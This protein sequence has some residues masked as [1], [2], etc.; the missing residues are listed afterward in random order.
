MTLR[1]RSAQP[2]NGE[3]PKIPARD[4]AFPPELRNRPARRK[5][6]RV[7]AWR[8]KFE[9]KICPAFVPLVGLPRRCVCRSLLGLEVASSVAGTGHHDM[10]PSKR[11]LEL[12]K[13]LAVDQAIEEYP[14]LARW[15]MRY[16]KT[17]KAAGEYVD[18]DEEDEAWDSPVAG[19][20]RLLCDIWPLAEG[21]IFLEWQT[22]GRPSGRGPWW[23]ATF[24]SPPRWNCGTLV[25]RDPWDFAFSWLYSASDNPLVR[26]ELHTLRNVS[27]TK[28]R[29]DWLAQAVLDGMRHDWPDREFGIICRRGIRSLGVSICGPVFVDSILD[30]T[31]PFKAKK[32]AD[33]IWWTKKLPVIPRK[34]KSRGFAGNAPR[35]TWQ[36]GNIEFTDDRTERKSMKIKGRR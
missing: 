25:L 13:I 24:E 34:R 36:D 29:Q 1:H 12:F 11:Y 19:T 16:V 27:L 10:K 30:E 6:A 7:Q 21:N 8:R 35:F 9:R 32:D 4:S 33:G 23:M 20:I 2:R 26:F 5:W 15:A 22:Y 28:A 17:A 14:E 18:F 31:A 3:L